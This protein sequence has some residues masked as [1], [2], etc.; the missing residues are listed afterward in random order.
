[1][2]YS[3]DLRRRVVCHVK[4]GGS[5][6]SAS[7]RYGV[8]RWCVYDWCSR[9]DLSPKASVRRKG[10]LNWEAVREYVSLHPDALLREI[11][12]HFSVNINAICYALHEM[13]IS[14]KKKLS[15]SGKKS[16]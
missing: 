16:R 4:S 1:M 3:L 11:A 5:K 15:V 8:S 7:K 12:S 14:Y 13:N 10:K 6:H 9:E 2:T